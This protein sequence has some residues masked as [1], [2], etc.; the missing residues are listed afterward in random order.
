MPREPSACRQHMAEL[1]RWWAGWARACQRPGTPA[2]AR[3]YPSGRQ[4][5]S[6][7]GGHGR[8]GGAAHDLG[9]DAVVGVAAGDAAKGERGQSGSLQWHSTTPVRLGSCQLGLPALQLAQG[10]WPAQVHGAPRS[11]TALAALL[12]GCACLGRGVH[13]SVGGSPAGQHDLGVGRQD[14]AR[15]QAGVQPDQLGGGGEELLGVVGAGR[16]MPCTA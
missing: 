1:L 11:P 8:G 6:P 15:R 7:P 3:A 2:G 9:V 13:A 10:N 14:A 12:Q 4:L 5:C 16:G